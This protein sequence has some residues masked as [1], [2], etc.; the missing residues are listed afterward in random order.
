MLVKETAGPTIILIGS[1][2]KRIKK[3]TL[4]IFSSLFIYYFAPLHIILED[5]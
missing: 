4:F 1:I 5:L 2:E 3:Y